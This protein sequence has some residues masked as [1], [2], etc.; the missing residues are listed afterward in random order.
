MI[1]NKLS[2]NSNANLYSEQNSPLLTLP[3]KLRSSH[4]FNQMFVFPLFYFISIYLV[5]TEP[6]LH[7]TWKTGESMHLFF[8][9][10]WRVNEQNRQRFEEIELFL[11]FAKTLSISRRYNNWYLQKYFQKMKYNDCNRAK[12][13]QTEIVS[14]IGK[15]LTI[16]GK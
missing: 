5:L 3:F 11:T 15:T 6:V 10:N 4:Y 16:S 8:N 1:Q 14:L 2:W 12:Y 13:N 7:G 9:S